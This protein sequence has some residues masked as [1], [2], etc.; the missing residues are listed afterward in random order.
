[1]YTLNEEIKKIKTM[2]ERTR[3]KINISNIIAIDY[4]EFEKLC[5]ENNLQTFLFQY[6]NISAKITV[7]TTIF[8]EK[9]KK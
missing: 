8:D 1:M 2:S 7:I 4:D 6:D 5:K 9:M 3:N